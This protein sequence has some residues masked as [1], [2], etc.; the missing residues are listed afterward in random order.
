M[1]HGI[2]RSTPAV[3]WVRGML[4]RVYQGRHQAYSAK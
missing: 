4:K 2:R 1:C 3:M